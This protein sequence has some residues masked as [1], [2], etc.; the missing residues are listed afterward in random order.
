M[1]V[2][3]ALLARSGERLSLDV[4]AEEWQIARTADWVVMNRLRA[5]EQVRFHGGGLDGSPRWSDTD[6]SADRYS[7]WLESL[8]RDAAVRDADLVLSD[9]LAGALVARPDAWLM[10][11]FLWHDV[12]RG[13]GPEADRIAAIEERLLA[14]ARPPMLCVG[15]IVMPEVERL[16]RAVPLPWFCEAPALRTSP[17][18]PLR[19]VLL[20]GGATDTAA[21]ALRALAITLHRETELALFLPEHIV[22]EP[23]RGSPRVRS[24]GF[25]E[26]EF[27]ACDLVIGRPGVGLLTDGVRFG[28]PLLC[29]DDEPNAEMRH[30][31]RR[32]EEL[33]IGRGIPSRDGEATA[34]LL[35]TELTEDT[36]LAWRRNVT[37]RPCG[38]VEAAAATLAR[39][40]ELIDHDA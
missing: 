8:H 11:S 1:R 19:A 13:T 33:G 40:L 16:A 31:A 14:D 30:N 39:A 25:R 20:A 22:P 37:S 5:S 24:F 34:R 9:N 26:A 2:A 36:Y 4:L 38:G 17:V 23:L 21:P 3:D 12:L 35:R 28:L 7:A 27:T 18:W 6:L 32:V 10:G 29:F 15:D